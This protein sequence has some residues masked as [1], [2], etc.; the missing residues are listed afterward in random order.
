[1]DAS[2]R[3]ISALLLLHQTDRRALCSSIKIYFNFIRLHNYV[4]VKAFSL[5]RMVTYTLLA[6]WLSGKTGR[7]VE[8]TGIFHNSHFVKNSVNTVLLSICN[9]IQISFL[10]FCN[11]Q[12]ISKFSCHYAQFSLIISSIYVHKHLTVTR[13]FISMWMLHILSNRGTLKTAYIAEDFTRR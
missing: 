2:A 3:G 1:M 11:I 9:T 12:I 4:K 10:I 5:H 13:V 8:I 7:L 6:M